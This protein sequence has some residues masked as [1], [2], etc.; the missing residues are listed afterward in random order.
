MITKYIV[1]FLTIVYSVHSFAGFMNSSGTNTFYG[2]LG[3]IDHWSGKIATSATSNDKPRFSN[4]YTYLHLATLHQIT[5]EWSLSPEFYFSIPNKKSPDGH[6]KFSVFGWGLRGVY[7][8]TDAWNFIVGLSG[9]YYGISGDGGDVV[10]NN[11]SSQSTFATP[12]TTETTSR[13]ALDLG[14]VYVFDQWRFETSLLISNATDFNKTSI[15]PML[16]L[17]RGF[18]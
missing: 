1:S 17:S 12:K 7:V 6:E 2:G 3:V 4:T 11:G 18:L 14:V 15:N 5:S 8:Y 9:M 10:Q 16:T 13:L